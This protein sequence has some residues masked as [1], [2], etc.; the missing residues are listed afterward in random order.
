MFCGGPSKYSLHV[1]HMDRRGDALRR[2]ERFQQAAGGGQHAR[3][4][5]GLEADVLDQPRRRLLHHEHL[6]QLDVPVVRVVH[7]H[8]AV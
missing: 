2:H 6:G 3:A 1:V 8:V 4:V 5:P 7:S